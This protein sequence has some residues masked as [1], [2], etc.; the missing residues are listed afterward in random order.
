MRC[1]FEPREQ[2]SMKIYRKAR[3]MRLCIEFF[4]YCLPISITSISL[5]S[6]SPAKAS[7]LPTQNQKEL[8]IAA[9]LASTLLH[10]SPSHHR[11]RCLIPLPT[12]TT[13]LLHQNQ[14]ITSLEN[15][16]LRTSNNRDRLW[17]Y[18]IERSNA[19]PGTDG[20]QRGQQRSS[21]GAQQGSNL[22]TIH[23][24]AH[25]FAQDRDNFLIPPRIRLTQ[26]TQQLHNYIQSQGPV[27]RNSVRELIRQTE[28][29]FHSIRD[30]F[31]TRQ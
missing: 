4:N 28:A 3:T 31:T 16:K 5:V 15:V 30:L 12:C 26:T 27:I 14:P 8:T 13:C 17:Q 19:T 7:E 22:A 1:R 25:T 2:R 29:T 11:P 6:Q 24:R 20:Q 18:M 23:P 21:S 10:R 9:D